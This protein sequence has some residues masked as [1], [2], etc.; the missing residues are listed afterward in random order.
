MARDTLVTTTVKPPPRPVWPSQSAERHARPRGEH[1]REARDVEVLAGQVRHPLRALPVQRV[2]EPDEGVAEA[3]HDRLRVHG[4]SSR[5]ASGEQQVEGEPERDRQQRGREDLGPVE[6]AVEA[7]EDQLAEAAVADDHPDRH[8]RDGRHGRHPDAGHDR[9]QRH[10]QL[11]LPEHPAPAVAHPAGRLAHVVRHAR[12]AR[13][14][15]C[16]RAPAARRAPGRPR[17]CAA[18]EPGERVDEREQRQR[19]DRVEHPGEPEQR[20]RP[21]TGTGTPAGPAGTR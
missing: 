4:V 7:A 13:P 20:R 1:D 21:A 14:A 12:R 19:R 17:R 10:R 15:C 2:V 6:V 5:V 9:R 18:R 11:D 8:Q 3:V 16:A